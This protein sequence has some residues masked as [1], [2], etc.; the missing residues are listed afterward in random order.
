MCL[1]KNSAISHPPFR[2]I[3]SEACAQS[4]MDLAGSG[5]HSRTDA[6]GEKLQRADAWRLL[7]LPSVVDDD[8]HYENYPF[9]PWEPIGTSSVQNSVARIRI[10][11][12][13]KTPSKLPTLDLAA[14]RR[15]DLG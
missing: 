9:A 2:I 15:F 3:H 7:F 11:V 14:R 12:L 5:P 8:L 10:H 13:L 6:S 4:F 1:I